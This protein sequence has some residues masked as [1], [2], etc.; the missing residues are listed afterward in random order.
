MKHTREKLSPTCYLCQFD[1]K[2]SED[3]SK[4]INF[5]KGYTADEYSKFISDGNINLKKICNKNKLKLNYMY[6]MLNNKIHLK[7]KYR[8]ALDSAI[9]EK[10]EYSEYIKKFESDG[11]VANG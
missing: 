2:S 9:F 6:D 10:S 5:K 4:C 7:F 1:C 11:V 8:V 3:M